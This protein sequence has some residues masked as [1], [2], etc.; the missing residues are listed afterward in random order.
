MHQPKSTRE[1][2]T[3]KILRDF[4]IETNPLLPI[5]RPDQLLINKKMKKRVLVISGFSVL[6]D[7]KL[8]MKES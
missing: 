6:E 8:K 7:Y 3:H 5:K 4:E 1:N 2:K